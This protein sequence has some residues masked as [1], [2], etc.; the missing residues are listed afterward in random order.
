M[1]NRKTKCVGTVLENEKEKRR[2]RERERERERKS[3][4]RT[5]KKN[6]KKNKIC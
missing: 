3:R 1:I 4:E 5:I 6:L 2:E